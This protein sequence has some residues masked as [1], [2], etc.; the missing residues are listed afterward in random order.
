MLSISRGQIVRQ[1]TT[2]LEFS[3]DIFVLHET[4]DVDGDGGGVGTH[5]LLQLLALGGKSDCGFT[6]TKRVNFILLFELF[7]KMFHE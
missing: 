7:S 4:L 3:C 6:L 5:Q 2:P 1:L